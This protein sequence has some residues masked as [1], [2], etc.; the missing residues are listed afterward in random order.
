M[1][2]GAAVSTSLAPHLSPLPVHPLPCPTTLGFVP[3]VGREIHPPTWSRQRLTSTTTPL[4]YWSPPSLP[5]VSLQMV[6]NGVKHHPMQVT[7]DVVLSCELVADIVMPL[8]DA[9]GS[10]RMGDATS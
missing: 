9:D 2:I 7:G 4:H 10:G 5:S 6:A 1:A 8:L 3:A